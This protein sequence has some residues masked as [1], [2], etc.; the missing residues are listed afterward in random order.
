MNAIGRTTAAWATIG[1]ALL[2]LLVVPA[3]A[4]PASASPVPMSGS[5][6][7]QWAYGAQKWVNVSETFGNASYTAHAFFGWQVVYTA[8][9]T[10]STT[11]AVEAQRTILGSYYAE[12]CDPNCVT[13]SVAYGNLTVVG[14]EKDAGF[15]NLTTTA[16]VT[17]NGSNVPAVGLVNA[18]ARIAGNI[19][20]TL[21]ATA[22]LKGFSGSTSAALYV[23]GAAHHEVSFSPALGLVPQNVS[24][25][26]TWNSSATFDAHGGWSILVN[27]SH[28]SVTG[29][30]SSGT[31]QPSGTVSGNG[32]V[33][34]YGED[35]G[36]VT[37][38]NGQTTPAIVL[39]WNG[40]FDNVDGVI[41]VPHDFDLFGDGEQSWA[42]EALTTQFAATQNLDIALDDH[43][44][45]HVVA[46][47]TSF[48]EADTSLA[49]TQ[50]VPRGAPAPATATT[51]TT[52][53]QGQPESVAQAQ[54]TSSCYTGSCTGVGSAGLSALVGVAVLVGL[55][56]AV[57]V[58][59]VSVVEY[60]QWARRRAE[61]GLSST[62]SPI[63]AAVPPAGAFGAAPPSPPASGLPREP[64][65]Q[66]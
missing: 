51:G 18:S 33:A 55:I 61:S 13:P 17:S 22:S 21:T 30:H 20:E 60:K 50:A 2:A 8:T 1:V 57:V 35:L 65:R 56:A 44:H 64:P 59:A 52:V 32:T 25:G 4:S 66:G 31:L 12:L 7:Q 26:Q 28:T 63:R 6:T 24:A 49:T 9:N 46:A 19:S 27:W 3:M 5:N 45:L 40:P 39:A 36:P 53:L 34:V 41:L 43:H 38:K 16:T 48:N 54:S 58:G 23:A 14:W 10:S 15:A 29:A 62:P 47:A 11:V 42:S 37:L